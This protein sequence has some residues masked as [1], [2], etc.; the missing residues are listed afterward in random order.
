MSLHP[1]SHVHSFARNKSLLLRA[2]ASLA[3]RFGG[4]A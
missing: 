3:Q 1:D 4:G 2:P